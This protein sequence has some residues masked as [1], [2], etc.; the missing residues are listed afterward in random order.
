MGGACS[1]HGRDGGHFVDLDIDWGIIVKWTLM[2]YRVV[3]IHLAQN[4]AVA[5]SCEHGSEPSG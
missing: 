5:G 4:R 1:P 2:E 3:W